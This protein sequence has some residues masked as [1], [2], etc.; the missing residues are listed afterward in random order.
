MPVKPDSLK[1][2]NIFCTVNRI[3][4]IFREA[5]SMYAAHTITISSPCNNDAGVLSISFYVNVLSNSK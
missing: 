4:L 1:T 5:A 3:T 2:N